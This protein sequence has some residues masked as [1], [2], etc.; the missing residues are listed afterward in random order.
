MNGRMISKPKFASVI[1]HSV[2][3]KRKQT[4]SWVF[5]I[6]DTMSGFNAHRMIVGHQVL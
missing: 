2:N 1:V 3:S 6:L 4:R 5:P